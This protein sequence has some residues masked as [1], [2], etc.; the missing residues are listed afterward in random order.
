MK[1]IISKSQFF[2]TKEDLVAE[3]AGYEASRPDLYLLRRKKTGAPLPV[4]P[5]RIQQYCDEGI[6]GRAVSIDG[7]EAAKGRYFTTRHLV[8]Y[9]AAIRFKKSGQPVSNLAG[10]LA[11]KSDQ[12]LETIALGDEAPEQPLHQTSERLKRLGRKEGKALKSR[13]LRYAIT[14]DIHVYLSEKILKNLNA[15]DVD[16]LAQAFKDA[17]LAEIDA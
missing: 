16:A 10:L 11:G 4:T 14:P 15:A 9:L 3:I 2:G 1:Q 7:K 6:I 5:R 12:D 13:Q 17:F 8:A